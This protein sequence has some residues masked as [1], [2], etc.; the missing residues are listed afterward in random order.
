M[1]L[2]T[3]YDVKSPPQEKENLPGCIL[4]QSLHVG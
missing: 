3:D 1:D 4:F 2:E